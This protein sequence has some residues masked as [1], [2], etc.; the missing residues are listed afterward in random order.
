MGGE[1]EIRS[2]TRK[3]HRGGGE[4]GGGGGCFDRIL[5]LLKPL[6]NYR[7]RDGGGAGEEEKSKERDKRLS[8]MCLLLKK[9]IPMETKTCRQL[10]R[11]WG[12]GG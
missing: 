10:N 6:Q 3:S 5:S 1:R 9:P 2:M 4:R 12:G 11:A 7:R 8:P